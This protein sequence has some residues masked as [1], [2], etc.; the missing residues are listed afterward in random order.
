MSSAATTELN[1]Q[2][3]DIIEE[4]GRAS[5]ATT[6][7]T[8]LIFGK[9]NAQIR[10]ETFEIAAKEPAFDFLPTY[11]MNHSELYRDALV[12]SKR[13][14]EILT[15]MGLTS[16]DDPRITWLRETINSPLP[17][18][19]HLTMFITTIAGQASDEQ[20]AKWLPK[21]FMLRYIGCYAQTELGHGSNVRGLETTATYD[22]EKEEFVMHSPTLTSTKWWPGGLGK[23]ANVAV[24]HARLIIKDKDYGVHAFFV[25]LRNAKDHSTLP[26]LVIGDI[27]PKF[28]YNAM[29][30]GYLRFNHYRIPRKNMLSRFQKVHP[31]GSYEKPP[32]AKLGYG[33]MTWTR[34]LIIRNASLVLA[35]GLTIA[36]RYSAVRR[37]FSAKPGEIERKVLDYQT[38]KY[39]LLPL[40][41]SSYAF[42]FTALWM[43]SMQTVSEKNSEKEDFSL[44]PE[45]HACSAGL[46]AYTTTILGDG[47][48][49]LR[50]CCG[51]HGFSSLSGLPQLL[52][53]H[54]SGYTL[55]GENVMIAQQ[56]TR[57]LIK[58]I[59]GSQ[60]TSESSTT[61]YLRGYNSHKLGTE[62]CR[63]ASAE[64]MCK[65]D[66]YLAALR[67]RTAYILVDIVDTLNALK[68]DKKMSHDEAWDCVLVKVNRCSKAHCAY[69]TVN[70]FVQAV[71]KPNIASPALTKTLRDLCDLY[72]LHTIEKDLADFLD[73]G[74]FTTQHTAFV[75]ERVLHYLDEVRPNAV[76]L[77]DAWDFT[78]HMLGSA[79]GCYDGNVYQRLQE[80]ANHEPLNRTDVI[81]FFESTLKPL[82]K[83]IGSSKL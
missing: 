49:V 20:Q 10:R 5:F 4:R 64:E 66:V 28:G 59:A 81:P 70:N 9:E 42:H 78:D 46:K 75:R 69:I 58:V 52:T 15:K 80:F 24:V 53:Y 18:D 37:Q 56:T 79:I 33:T 34:I 14:I 67:H 74:Y 35:R 31:D 16:K 29:D 17:I 27:G 39:Q 60:T 1:Q 54:I 3:R 23:T 72:A 77:V 50:R 21:C 43:D 41:A 44:V 25:P 13:L 22:V 82:M 61:G 38:Q 51:G 32:K 65:P 48:E 63:A 40:L 12:K 7:L 19:L 6:E 83:T 11:F 30:N 71:A 73:D 68:V 57:Y 45:L 8:E 62:K 55:E 36:I 47:L 26:G 76:A 2:Q